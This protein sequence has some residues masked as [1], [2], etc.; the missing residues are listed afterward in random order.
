VAH[1]KFPLDRASLDH[2]WKI[3]VSAE[4]GEV[5]WVK[6]FFH[7]SLS[8]WLPLCCADLYSL[9]S[10]VCFHIFQFSK[11]RKA[12]F[13]MKFSGFWVL[14]ANSKSFQHSVSQTELACGLEPALGSNLTLLRL[15][16]QVPNPSTPPTLA[17]T[18]CFLPSEWH[19]TQAG[20]PFLNTTG[21]LQRNRIPMGI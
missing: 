2:R 19:K 17:S 18:A 10:K 11:A 5:M 16:L 4:V 6:E 21:V 7:H 8:T 3:P 12:I 1:I 20:P 15:V 13:H 9:G 14:A